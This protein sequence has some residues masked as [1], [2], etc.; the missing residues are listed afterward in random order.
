MI[1]IV[2]PYESLYQVSNINYQMVPV[3]KS[4]LQAIDYLIKIAGQREDVK[5]VDD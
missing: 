5:T 3:K 1:D 4:D 2:D